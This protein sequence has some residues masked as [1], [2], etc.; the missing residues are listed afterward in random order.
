M[1]EMEIQHRMAQII[2]EFS[3]LKQ[4]DRFDLT[5][6][7]MGDGVIKVTVV[8]QIRK[9]DTAERLI[10]PSEDLSFIPYTFDYP[11]TITPRTKPFNKE[12][13]E[14]AHIDELGKL[15]VVHKDSTERFT[16]SGIS[17]EEALKKV[18]NN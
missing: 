15:V 10:K 16:L 14:S 17:K 1:E 18:L 6:E 4:M 3:Q 5:L 11:N 8:D 7:S 9:N 2:N 12:F 13:I